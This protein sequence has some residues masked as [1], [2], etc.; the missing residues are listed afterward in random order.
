MPGPDDF[1]ET[2][3]AHEMLMHAMEVLYSHNQ[4]L[5][6]RMKEELDAA[7]RGEENILLVGTDGDF[8]VTILHVDP[9]FTGGKNKI[10]LLP[11]SSSV[12]ILAAV[13]RDFIEEKIRMC[14]IIE[15]GGDGASADQ[16]WDDF[17]SDLMAEVVQMHKKNP[18]TF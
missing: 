9:E 5:A 18:K 3:E 7:A 14:E 2:P 13:D 11:T 8:T 10:I 15:D 6:L 12:S 17:M 16:I 1:S 4:E